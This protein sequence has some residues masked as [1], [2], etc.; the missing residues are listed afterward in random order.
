MFS[1]VN[2]YVAFYRGRELVV[3]GLT[4]YDAQWEA[5]KKFKAR[6]A[7]EVTVILAEK[8]NGDPVIHDPAIL[9]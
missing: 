3:Q 2:T 4:S 9:D 5:A 8:P 7:Y 1:G 6:K